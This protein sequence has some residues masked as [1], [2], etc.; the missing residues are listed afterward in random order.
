MQ[1]RLAISTLQA[2]GEQTNLTLSDLLD[3]KLI[4][5]QQYDLIVDASPK[6]RVDGRNKNVRKFG[7]FWE[8]GDPRD[9]QMSIFGEELI[10][11]TGNLLQRILSLPDEPYDAIVF[12]TRSKGKDI[13]N[14]VFVFDQDNVSS[15]ASP[16]SQGKVSGPK[17]LAAKWIK[18]TDQHTNPVSQK[19]RGWPSPR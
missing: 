11:S 5:Q 17:E 19:P 4:D 7:K 1:T 6:N 14:R 3:F 13:V 2:L 9:L 12:K 8:G 15:Y 18:E 16:P 10:D